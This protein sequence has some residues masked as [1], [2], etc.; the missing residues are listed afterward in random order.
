MFTICVG[1]G[2]PNGLALI[3]PQPM[4]YIGFGTYGL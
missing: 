1:F 4:N 2:T 3:K